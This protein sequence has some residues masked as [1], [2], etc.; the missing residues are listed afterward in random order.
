[1]HTMKWYSINV[2]G[3]SETKAR[4]NGMKVVDGASH[5]YTQVTEGRA[6]CGVAIIMAEEWAN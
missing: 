5:V 6:K 2:L 4:G 1:M 3:L